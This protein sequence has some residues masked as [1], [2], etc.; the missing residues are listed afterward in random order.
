M[1][2]ALTEPLNAIIDAIKQTLERTEPEL[3]A[4]LTDN[5]IVLTGGGALLGKLDTLIREKTQ[6]PV[7]IAQD[8]LFCVVY[9][10]GKA[11]SELDLYKTLALD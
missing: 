5:G 3:A 6:L 8:P 7:S 9:G 2:E 1:R 11:L 4:D 10:S